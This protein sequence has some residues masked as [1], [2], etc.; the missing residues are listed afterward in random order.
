M[1]LK[2]YQHIYASY[3][4]TTVEIDGKK[5]RITFEGGTNNNPTYVTAKYSTRDEKVQ[6]E[7]EKRKDF[8]TEITIFYSEPLPQKQEPVIPEDFTQVPGISTALAAKSYL[9]DRFPELKH[10]QLKNTAMVKE[11]AAQKKIAFTDL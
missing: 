10:E 9:L 7:I 6:A 3:L 1:G 2:V 11:V 4:S 5:Q 8:G